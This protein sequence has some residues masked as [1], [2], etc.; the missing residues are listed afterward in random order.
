MRYEFLRGADN[1]IL[2]DCLSNCDEQCTTKDM[3][4]DDTSRADWNI[5]NIKD[6]LNGQKRYSDAHTSPAPVVEGRKKCRTDSEGDATKNV[7]GS[8]VANDCD[9]PAG[10]N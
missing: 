8:V 10:Y 4:E 7:E 2:E 3:K 6:G 9:Q 1:A 5:F